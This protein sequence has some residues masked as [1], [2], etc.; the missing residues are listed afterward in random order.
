MAIETEGGKGKRSQMNRASDSEAGGGSMKKGRW[1]TQ[2]KE[3][4]VIVRAEVD[5]QPHQVQGPW[6]FYYLLCDD[7]FYFI[8]LT[9]HLLNH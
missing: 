6:V 4:K 5:N 9:N 1:T 2:T 3:A 8:F 7:P